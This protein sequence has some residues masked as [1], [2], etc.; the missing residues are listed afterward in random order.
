M[1]VC[2]CEEIS[3]SLTSYCDMYSS[4]WN[5]HWK[6]HTLQ[7]QTLC[8]PAAADWVVAQEELTTANLFCI[9]NLTAGDLLHV[10]VVAVNRSGR[11]EP[12]TLAQSVPIRE[13]GGE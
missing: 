7:T 12:G 10:R 2:V 13:I 5:Q 1:Y 11:S 4:K 9:K 6:L 8:S 3:C